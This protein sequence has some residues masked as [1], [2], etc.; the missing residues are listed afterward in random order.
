MTK[1][2]AKLEVL[3]TEAVEQKLDDLIAFDARS[4]DRITFFELRRILPKLIHA[5]RAWS[6]HFEKYGCI[7]CPTGRPDSTPAIAARLRRR[8]LS[9]SAIF[10]DIGRPKMTGKERRN[11]RNAVEHHLKHPDAPDREPSA[12]LYGGGG[13]CAQCQIQMRRELLRI[14]REMHKGRDAEE[15]TAALT[16]RSDVA[17]G[18]LSGDGQ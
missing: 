4:V 2:I 14:I 9:W 5:S 18:L 16:R 3:L 15:E 6:A 7:G 11:F 17:L 12:H 8:G 10:M 1:Q 13:F